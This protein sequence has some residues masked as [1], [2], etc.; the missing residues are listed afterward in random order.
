MQA[1][2]R[3]SQ[4]LLSEIRHAVSDMKKFTLEEEINRGS[5]AL[6]D[7]GFEV[8]SQI[9]AGT[10]SGLTA[11][12][13]THLAL[14]TK[15]AMTNILRHSNGKTVTIAARWEKSELD[16]TITD[17]GKTDCMNAGNGITG[18]RERAALIGAV[19]NLTFGEHTTLHIT[20][21]LQKQERE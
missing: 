20:L 3:L 21:P 4:S 11:L 13:E 6:R 12:Q 8:N 5:A 9:D 1:L 14:I 10:L 17:N 16:L 7:M 19:L 18:M 2:T 15:E